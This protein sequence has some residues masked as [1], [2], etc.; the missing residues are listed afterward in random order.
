MEDSL[1]FMPKIVKPVLEKKKKQKPWH[2][3]SISIASLVSSVGLGCTWE[4]GFVL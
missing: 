2:S 3:G 4:S 1:A